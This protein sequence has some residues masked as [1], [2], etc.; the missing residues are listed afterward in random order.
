MANK[1]EGREGG[2]IST[3]KQGLNRILDFTLHQLHAAGI[4]VKEAQSKQGWEK[5]SRLHTAKRT[6]EESA[7]MLEEYE[8][9]L[10]RIKKGY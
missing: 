6:I 2:I 8:H 7:D 1:I 9:E 10:V 5:L 3:R 4:L